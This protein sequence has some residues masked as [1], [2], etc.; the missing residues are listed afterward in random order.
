MDGGEDFR[1]E[2]DDVFALTGR[3]L[4]VV[5]GRI[6]DGSIRVGDQ[7]AITYQGSTELAE[8]R[9]ASGVRSGPD[10]DPSTCALF[11]DQELAASVGPGALV[12]GG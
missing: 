5:L 2:V 3:E 11:I 12:T 7:V 10:A 1:F 9:G 8:L 4:V 6:T